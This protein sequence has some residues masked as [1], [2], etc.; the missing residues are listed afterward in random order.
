MKTFDGIKCNNLI[1]YKKFNNVHYDL[2]KISLI[3]TLEKVK[4]PNCVNV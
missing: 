2:I 3:S 1:N 4:N